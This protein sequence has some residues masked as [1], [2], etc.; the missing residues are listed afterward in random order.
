MGIPFSGG[1]CDDE[2]DSVTW[3]STTC[4][5]R[6]PH[7]LVSPQSPHRL[8]G[9]ERVCVCMC[10]SHT[11]LRVALGAERARFEQRLA[12]QHTASVHIAAYAQTGASMHACTPQA[13]DDHVRTADA[14]P[15]YAPQQPHGSRRSHNHT[16]PPSSLSSYLSAYAYRHLTCI[17]LSAYAYRQRTCIDVIEGIGDAAQT[18]EEGIVE[19][20]W[21]APPHGDGAALVPTQTRTYPGTHAN[22]AHGPWL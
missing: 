19:H 3:G 6:R 9:R 13:L 10:V 16:A 14:T 18:R 22:T 1:S 8:K 5:A 21:V 15:M 12:E 4:S 20:A 11:C 2:Y 17:D 7:P